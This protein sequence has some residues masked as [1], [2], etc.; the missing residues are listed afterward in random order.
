[1]KHEICKTCANAKAQTYR[2]KETGFY[3]CA[4][5]DSWKFW[6]GSH[7]CHIRRWVG[8][9]PIEPLSNDVRNINDPVFVS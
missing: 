5:S 2:G 1:M 3:S 9:L 8:R 7:E 4:V 6:A